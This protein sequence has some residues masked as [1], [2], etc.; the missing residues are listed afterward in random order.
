MTDLFSGYIAAP[1][2]DEQ[3]RV[4][5]SLAQ[6]PSPLQACRA[7]NWRQELF[8]DEEAAVVFTQIM[9]EQRPVPVALP[10]AL[11]G[12]VPYTEEELRQAR[13]RMARAVLLSCY[14]PRYQ[15]NLR[16][17]LFSLTQV[18]L[19]GESD[20]EAE[21]TH[22]IEQTLSTM[23]ASLETLRAIISPLPREAMTAMTQADLDAQYWDRLAAMRQAIPT[24]FRSLTTI[25]NGGLHTGRVITFLGGPGGGKTT[26]CNQLGEYAATLGR[27]VVYVACEEPP[28]TLYAKTLARLGQVSYAA[29]QFGWANEREA[30][31]HARDVCRSRQSSQR[32][33][34]VEGFTDLA[35]L[36]ELVQRHF[37]RYEDETSGGGP[38]VLIVDYLQC[39]AQMVSR[40]GTGQ[41]REEHQLIGLLMYELR[42]MAKALNC[43]VLVISSQSRASGYGNSHAL[44]SGR[45]SGFIEYASDVLISL[46]KDEETPLPQR[47]KELGFEW[48]KLALPKNRLG[49]PD[50]CELLWRGRYQEFAELEDSPPADDE[51]EDDDEE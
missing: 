44:T 36:Q 12:L 28:A 49:S 8:I 15:S 30:I 34:Y 32:L 20:V 46:D 4:V 16:D 14:L 27:P 19:P 6:M 10:P 31:D 2:V 51:E 35:S 21:I 37:Q 39:I 26:F 13:Q 41:T 29:A 38:G 23:D 17:R 22:L 50:G 33:L 3:W 18:R 1:T 7:S 11:D 43:T 9:N 47:M 24:G 5:L 48:R 45:G 40:S 25:L 42:L